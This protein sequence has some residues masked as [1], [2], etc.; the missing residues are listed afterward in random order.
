MS[1]IPDTPRQPRQRKDR[2]AFW[3]GV[4]AGF[5]GI[6]GVYAAVIVAL[7]FSVLLDS[8]IWDDVEISYA[9]HSKNTTCEH[10]DFT[11]LVDGKALS[12]GPGSAE[13]VKMDHKTVILSCGDRARVDDMT[14][15]IDTE[16]LLVVRFPD[17]ERVSIQCED[18]DGATYWIRDETGSDS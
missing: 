11:V 5:G 16:Y 17:S 7:N 9:S 12:I 3:R 15:A 6:L 1:Q 14:C 4:F 8:R 18:V 2:N 13:V 10:Q